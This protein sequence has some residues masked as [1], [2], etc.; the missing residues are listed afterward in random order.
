MIDDILIDYRASRCI[1]P[2]DLIAVRNSNDFLSVDLSW[3]S[4]DFND[5]GF[6]VFSQVV[7][8][9]HYDSIYSITNAVTIPNLALNTKYSFYVSPIELKN[10]DFDNGPLSARFEQTINFC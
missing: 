7:N 10:F 3:Q 9:N 1:R 2:D 8:S 4:R 5:V 6:W